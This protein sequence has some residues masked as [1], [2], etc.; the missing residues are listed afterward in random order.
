MLALAPFEEDNKKQIMVS[1][2]RKILNHW[3]F[4]DTKY[5]SFV[6]QKSFPLIVFIFSS[7]SFP[8]LLAELYFCVKL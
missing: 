4:N 6:D 2:N 3:Y 7:I 1:G 5:Q 8:N